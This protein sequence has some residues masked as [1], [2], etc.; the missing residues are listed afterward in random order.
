MNTIV[1]RANERGYANHGWLE[2]N[3]SFSFASWYNS[4]R[5]GF[6]LL[7]V[8]NDDIIAPS[9]GFD[10]HPHRNMEIISIPVSG[11]LR[12][13]DNGGNEEVI[14][15][16]D[17]QVMSAGTGI[18]HSEYNASDTENANFLQL[19]IFPK[20]A[21]IA[22]RYDQKSFDLDERKNRFQ[23]LASGKALNGALEINQD[24]HVSI[25]NLDSGKSLTYTVQ[26]KGNGVY[27][28]VIRGAI[29]AGGERLNRK[30]A[31]GFWDMNEIAIDA[32]EDTEV[33]VVEVPMN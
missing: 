10:I 3:H 11:A 20:Q 23:F 33:L 2:S 22:P 28:F 21:N 26:E 9:T 14:R 18:Y 19:W 8:L 24:A 17:V 30:D 15:D 27:L 4:E 29:A 6:G 16:S 25:T 12:H 5:M 13:K 7:R 31:A 32:L 1:H